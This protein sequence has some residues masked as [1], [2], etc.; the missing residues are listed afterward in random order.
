MKYIIIL[1]WI[2]IKF[3]ILVAAILTSFIFVIL[4]QYQQTDNI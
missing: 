3:L 1:F 2:S 4:L